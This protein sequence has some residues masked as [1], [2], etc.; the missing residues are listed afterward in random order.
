MLKD[1]ERKLARQ[2]RRSPVIPKRLLGAFNEHQGHLL[3]LQK[4]NFVKGIEDE[5]SVMGM[6]PIHDFIYEQIKIINFIYSNILT[7]FYQQ[8]KHAETRIPL[9]I[10]DKRKRESGSERESEGR[11]SKKSKKSKKAKKTKGK[12]AK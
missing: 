11:E 5:N 7:R 1:S 8:K 3:A 2:Q 9:A 10:S 4:L 12:K 6:L